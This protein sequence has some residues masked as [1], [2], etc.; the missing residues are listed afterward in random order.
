[1]SRAPDP[2]FPGPGTETVRVLIVD[3]EPTLRLG[4][5]FA[6]RRSGF[7]VAEARCGAE[8]LSALGN[9]VVYDVVLLDLR[10]PDLD[11]LEVIQRLRASGDET[12][13][14][15]CSAFIEAGSMVEAVAQGVADFLAKPVRPDD[16]RSAVQQIIEPD[17]DR[18]S[19]VREA[20]RRRELEVAAGLLESAGARSA[21]E[22]A[23]LHVIRAASVDSD[24]RPVLAGRLA[25]QSLELVELPSA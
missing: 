8:A 20:V 13:I 22:S 7:E 4:F 25:P 1:M 17:D 24:Q 14:I 5:S 12:R 6:L 23:W 18:L 2:N 21:A 19:R 3:D 9:G 16:L 11:G 10:M 15:L